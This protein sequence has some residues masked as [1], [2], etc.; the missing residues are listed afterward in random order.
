M[1]LSP[2]FFLPGRAR[3][4]TYLLIRVGMRY[5]NCVHF[6]ALMI[7]FSWFCN[8]FPLVP[9]LFSP[10]QSNAQEIAAPA[11]ARGHT[12]AVR[13]P[14]PSLLNLLVQSYY[15]RARAF[16]YLLVPLKCGMLIAFLFKR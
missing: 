7:V 5:V 11:S 16:T 8:L 3:A 9:F 13:P 2:L 15:W 10:L 1:V 14:E 4:F 12:A 6:Q